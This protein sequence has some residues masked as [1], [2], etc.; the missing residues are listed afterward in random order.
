MPFPRSMDR[1]SS[2]L[3]FSTT[4]EKGSKTLEVFKGISNRLDAGWSVV[5]V[6]PVDMESMRI[7][8]LTPSGPPSAAF[9]VLLERRRTTGGGSAAGATGLSAELR[10]LRGPLITETTSALELQL[11]RRLLA[12]LPARHRRRSDLVSCSERP[13]VTPH[14]EDWSCFISFNLFNS[15]LLAECVVDEVLA[16]A[17]PSQPSRVTLR[18]EIEKILAHALLWLGGPDDPPKIR[19]CIAR[20]THKNAM[21]QTAIPVEEGSLIWGFL[22]TVDRIRADF[23]AE[24]ARLDALL[25]SLA[26]DPG[27]AI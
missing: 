11:L 10:Y 3:E 15:S 5:S 6:N 16:H 9:S 17:L 13:R 25:P 19:W 4:E 2:L 23:F 27:P 14:T 7:G 18:A 24:R 26:D 22:D 20:Y 21:G 8:V 12:K 1:S